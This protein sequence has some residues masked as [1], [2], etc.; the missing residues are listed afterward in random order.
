V[1]AQG[2]SEKERIS[3]KMLAGLVLTLSLLWPLAEVVLGLSSRTQRRTATKHDRGSLI[4]LWV[5]IGV[6][7]TAALVLRSVR[8][9]RMRLPISVM[10]GLALALLLGGLAIRL[11]AIITLGRFFTS[12]V[13]IQDQHRIVT[14]GLY[15]WVR[16][17][18]YAGLLLAF[19]G[20]ACSYGNWLSL[21]AI[22]VPITAAVLY[23]IHVE[24]AA[25]TEAF[26]DEYSEYR[27]RTRRLIPGLY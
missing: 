13:T 8:A 3:L 7:I 10:L 12:T 25:L 9:T 22:G 14:T 26:G 27:A 6:G 11:T 2:A 19:L 20:V 5:S 4:L 17:P 24:E 15:R 16:H 1:P 21:A 18:S 23:R